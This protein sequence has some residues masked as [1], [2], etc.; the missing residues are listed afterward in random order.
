MVTK[1]HYVNGLALSVIPRLPHSDAAVLA[2][3]SQELAIRAPGKVADRRCI[4][5]EA[6]CLCKPLY[7]ALA[8]GKAPLEG[9]G[10][11]A[12][13]LPPRPSF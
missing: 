11:D 8:A 7:E 10:S 12:P 4:S 2:P 13:I 9:Q 6:V 1:T 3:S 5:C